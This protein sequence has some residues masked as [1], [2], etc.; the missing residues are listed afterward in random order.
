MPEKEL[1]LPVKAPETPS[2]TAS[3]Q[4][5]KAPKIG[6]SDLDEYSIKAQ[7]QDIL[8]QNQ[9]R[10]DSSVKSAL[11]E[12]ELLERMSEGEAFKGIKKTPE[13]FEQQ[14]RRIEGRIREYEQRLQNDPGDDY[15]R[16][17][18]HGLY[19]LKSTVEGLKKAVVEK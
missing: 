12:S 11:D 3:T 5:E 9:R 18:L 2:V 8:F 15:A 7:E 1:P 6:S 10:W 13:Q 19:M 17:K 16:Q 14:L 4:E